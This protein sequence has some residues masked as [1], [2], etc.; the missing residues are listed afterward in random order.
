MDHRIRIYNSVLAPFDSYEAEISGFAIEKATNKSVPI[1]KFAAYEGPDNFI[2]SS[3]GV[4]TTNLYTYDPGTGPT[5]VVTDSRVV[6]VKATKSLVAK[7]FTICLLIVNAALALGST[8]VTLVVI[9]KRG[10]GVHDGVLLLPV[11]I[12]L[13]IPALRGLYVGSPPFG[14]FL[15][16][17]QALRSEFVGGLKPLSDTFCFFPQMMIV[18]L[19]SMVLLHFTT[20]PSAQDQRDPCDNG[21]KQSLWAKG[22]FKFVTGVV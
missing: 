22:G 9:T 15:G 4:N 8:Y 13:T 10:E 1:L 6:T 7:V 3:V 18:A 20:T 5:K 17:S 11:T 12:I 14:I 16:R 2:V 21:N 19:C